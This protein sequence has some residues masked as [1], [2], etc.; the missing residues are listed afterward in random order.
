M[1]ENISLVSQDYK[2]LFQ[3]FSSKLK[4]LETLKNDFCNL[5]KEYDKVSNKETLEKCE[6]KYKILEEAFEKVLKEAE[7]VK[8]VESEEDILE[9]VSNLEEKKEKV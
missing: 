7:E 1:K 4:V 8:K 2:K 9:T 5:L 6:K 3:I